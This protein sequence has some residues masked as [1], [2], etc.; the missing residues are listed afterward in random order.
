MPA[1]LF[2]HD[3]FDRDRIHEHGEYTPL[4]RRVKSPP[5]VIVPPPMNHRPPGLRPDTMRARR[6]GAE[7]TDATEAE[8]TLLPRRV[9]PEQAAVPGRVALAASPAAIALGRPPTLP[10]AVG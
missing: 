1:V 3:G 7:G 2:A 4:R 10:R 5:R 9:P 8:E 6:G